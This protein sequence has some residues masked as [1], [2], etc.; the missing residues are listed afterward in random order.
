MSCRCCPPFPPLATSDT[1]LSPP[2]RLL[3]PPVLEAEEARPEFDIA[4]YGRGIVDR[5]AARV[6]PAAA[7]TTGGADDSEDPSGDSHPRLSAPTG[8]RAAAEAV[9]FARVLPPGAPRYEVCRAFLATLQLANAG[10][11]EIVPPPLPQ[12]A[13]EQPSAGGRRQGRARAPAKAPADAE[14][15]AFTQAVVY[16]GEGD[17]PDAVVDA[18]AAGS[19]DAQQQRRRIVAGQAMALEE[20]EARGSEAT[21]AF[22]RAF[23]LRLLSTSLPATF[24]S[25]AAAAASSAA[26][27]AAEAGTSGP[28][29]GQTRGARSKKAVP[30]GTS[31]AKARQESSEAGAPSAPSALRR[32]NSATSNS[33]GAVKADSGGAIDAVVI[34][35]AGEADPAMASPAHKRGRVA[36]DA[37]HY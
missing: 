2:L 30:A 19:R 36:G 22:F 9:T 24:D 11:V 20:E 35:K 17:V 26:V 12:D 25:D 33:G 16:A 34:R 6:D 10:N 13:Q 1:P 21:G 31:K 7:A 23:S 37:R 28:P 8:A 32:S 5:L 4:S 15:W 27:A 18:A 14:S 29:A 3:P